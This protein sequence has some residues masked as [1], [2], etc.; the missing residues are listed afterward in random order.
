M[1]NDRL[2]TSGGRVLTITAV[3][4]TVAAAAERAGAFADEV[5][6]SGKQFRRDIGW[7]EVARNA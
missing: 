2:L 3:A 5:A 7:R 4:E 1:E 6:F